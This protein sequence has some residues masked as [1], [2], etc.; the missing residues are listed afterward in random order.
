M[1]NTCMYIQNV[2]AH[3]GVSVLALV[4]DLINR[5]LSACVRALALALV[6]N[7]PQLAAQYCMEGIPG[8]LLG[9]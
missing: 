6:V 4:V 8:R 1:A 2:Y 9:R 3:A 5:E 7:D